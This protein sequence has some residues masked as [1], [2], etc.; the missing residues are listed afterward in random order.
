MLA[1]E[2]GMSV[3]AFHA[4]FKAV[5]LTS[6]MQYLKTTRLHKARLLMV[7]DG[8]SAAA[9]SGRAQHPRGATTRA[10]ALTRRRAPHYSTWRSNSQVP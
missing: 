6:P 4:N 1:S 3:A 7:Q 9:A 10:G 5:T 8:T 2:A